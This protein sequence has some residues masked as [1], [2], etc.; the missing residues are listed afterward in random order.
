MSSGIE[1][2]RAGYGEFNARDVDALVARLVPDFQWH[3]AA[4]IP[5]RKSCTSREEFVRYMRGFGAVWQ[6]FSLKPEDVTVNGDAVYAKVRVLARGRASEIDVELTVHH[7][8]RKRDG[9]FIRM[10]AYL[11]EHAARAAAGLVHS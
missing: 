3:E 7:V 2:T 10:D 11:S 1:K 8:W 6:E 9:V 5:G 4:E